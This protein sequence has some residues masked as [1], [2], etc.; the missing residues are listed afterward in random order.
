MNPGE[1]ISDTPPQQK[2]RRR[3]LMAASLLIV[4]IA[5]WWCWPRG[6]ARF[7]G[8][9]RSSTTGASWSFSSNGLLRLQQ[10][11]RVDLMRWQF[12]DGILVVG[13][14]VDS[15]RYWVKDRFVDLFQSLT[16]VLLVW[17]TGQEKYRVRFRSPDE[18]ELDAGGEKHILVRD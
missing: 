15:P 2:R 10:P 1:Q 6:D 18:I 8:N 7:V 17:G 16:G 3:R 4:S 9:F 14:P 11:A 13:T 12:I 5:A